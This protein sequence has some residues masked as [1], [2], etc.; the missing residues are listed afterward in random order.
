MAEPYFRMRETGGPYRGLFGTQ[1]NS[2]YYSTDWLA[3]VKRFLGELGELPRFAHS[4]GACAAQRAKRS[5][6]AR[7]NICAYHANRACGAKRRR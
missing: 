5:G 4:L 7:R 2:I 3:V 1:P 6:F